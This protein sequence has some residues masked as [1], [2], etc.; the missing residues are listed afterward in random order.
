MKARS[1]NTQEASPSDPDYNI[2]RGNTGG[3]AWGQKE[4]D[5]W[6]IRQKN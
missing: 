6:K 5:G 1:T 4:G 3:Y 2:R